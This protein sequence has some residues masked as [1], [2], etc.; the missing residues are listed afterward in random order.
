MKYFPF[1]FLAIAV[2]FTALTV[3]QAI[4]RDDPSEGEEKASGPSKF[5]LDFESNGLFPQSLVYEVS[6]GRLEEGYVDAESGDCFLEFLYSVRVGEGELKAETLLGNLRERIDAT[7]EADID[8]SK[9]KDTVAVGNYERG[10]MQG[11]IRAAASQ[12]S[13]QEVEFYFLVKEMPSDAESE[14]R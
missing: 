2:G 13:E 11:I 4:T 8:W 7:S 9:S 3:F 14:K 12:L 1:V 10:G 5:V 6:G